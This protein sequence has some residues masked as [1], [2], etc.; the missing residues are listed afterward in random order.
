M[1]LTPDYWTLVAQLRWVRNNR[2]IPTL[3][4]DNLDYRFRA[5]MLSASLWD[6][7]YLLCG[8][9]VRGTRLG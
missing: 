5:D 7:A 3:L 4:L 8:R 2:M 9:G 1:G 6:S